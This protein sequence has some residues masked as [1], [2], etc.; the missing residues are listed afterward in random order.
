MASLGRRLRA[1]LRKSIRERGKI[2][3]REYL[4]ELKKGEKVIIKIDSSY[5]KGMP[6]P[7]FHGKIGIVEGKEGKFTYLV[8]IRDGGKEKII[9]SHVIHLRRF[10][11]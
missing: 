11:G 9:K 8:K 5:Q 1:K 10:G 7:R 6:L 2:K 4:K 3:I